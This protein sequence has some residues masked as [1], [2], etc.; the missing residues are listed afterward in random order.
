MNTNLM[1]QPL[2]LL[3]WLVPIASWA[4]HSS[5]PGAADGSP[6]V[7]ANRDAST[8]P[9]KTADGVA[10]CRAVLKLRSVSDGVYQVGRSVLP[11]KTIETQ[12]TTLSDEDLKLMGKRHVKQYEAMVRFTVDA[13]GVPQDICVARG[14]GH[15]L[16]PKVV[17]AVT[18]YRFKPATLDGKPVPMRLTVAMDFRLYR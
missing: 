15:G 9:L 12:E 4:Q 13:N 2:L 11:P 14:A 3:L 10:A 5:P 7:S 17:E 6:L 16:D 1:R 18:K 8:T